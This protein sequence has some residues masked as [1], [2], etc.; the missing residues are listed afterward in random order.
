MPDSPIRRLVKHALA[1]EAAGITVHYLNIGQPDL[2]SPQEFWD[3]I[4]ACDFDRL[5]YEHSLGN[6]GLRE[7][8][9][10]H[11]ARRGKPLEL[12][13]ILVTNGGSEAALVAFLT[14]FDPG[15][16]VIVVE[17]LYA[18]FLSFAAA[19]GVT[20]VPVTTT[21]ENHF[22]LP[23][24]EQLVAKISAR[25]RGILLCNP[26]N[27]T[28][29]VYPPAQLKEIA[30]VVKEH[31][32]FLVV[33]EV[34]GDFYYGDD[35]CLSALQVAG[36]EDQT[37]ILDSASKKLS[38]CGARVGFMVSKNHEVMTQALKFAQARLSVP[39]L[40]QI[41]VA[42]C[43]RNTP[44]SYFDAVRTQY[45]ERRDLVQ[46]E[47]AL[48]PGVLCPEIHGAFYAMVRLPVADSD[49]FCEWLVRDFRLDGET[50]L[51]APASGFYI[52]PGKGRDEV[53]IAY[54]LEV[55]RLQ[56]AMRVLAAALDEY[57]AAR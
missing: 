53:R 16:E 22:A 15:D 10:E 14:L 55:G 26:T 42:N 27:P 43:L 40:E 25:T 9:V 30:R 37:I 2:A 57:R 20:L 6:I 50:L 4:A 35:S 56:R 32:L 54:V 39:T 7:A 19:A 52:T 45:I 11:Y 46:R 29:T 24:T 28:G 1:A 8:F 17:P 18:N 12:D 13:D 47:L 23:A 33:D 21:I 48:M 5:E 3:G 41:G 38:L 36:I 31:D 51:L 49:A 44:R 34:Y